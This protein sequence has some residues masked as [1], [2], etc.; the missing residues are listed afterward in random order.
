MNMNM[1][2]TPTTVQSG[3]P[4]EDLNISV[5]VSKTDSSGKVKTFSVTTDEY[6]DAIRMLKYAGIINP[7]EHVT[8]DDGCGCG[9]GTDPCSC[10]TDEMDDDTI[11]VQIDDQGML[12]MVKE[13]EFVPSADKFN[14]KRKDVA[15]H[16][17]KKLKRIRDKKYEEFRNELSNI[18]VRGFNFSPFWGRKTQS[19]NTHPYLQIYVSSKNKESTVTNLALY[20]K[21][22]VEKLEEFGFRV[23]GQP[24]LHGSKERR[25]IDRINMY[26][27]DTNV[28]LFDNTITNES[29]DKKESFIKKN[30]K[31]F[32]KRYGDRWEQV[33]YAT[34]NKMFESE[35]I[36][37]DC[38][39][40]FANS[41]GKGN[42]GKDT[43]FAKVT[44]TGDVG[45]L[46][47]VCDHLN[48]D[49]TDADFEAYWNE[50][51]KIKEGLTKK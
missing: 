26:V 34:A 39:V 49:I 36:E 33:L 40:G 16:D 37:E 17:P 19:A 23:V 5:S 7:E 35:E 31:D 12:S 18:K 9:C 4:S 46:D 10:S 14:P 41:L 11:D 24:M 48:D 13:E 30:K 50:F 2:N 22:L 32:K 1:A 8:I 29:E 45:E 43:Q 3:L 20:I 21:L 15:E 44:D 42:N 51:T 27:D 25:G 6:E 38:G 28:D 47:A